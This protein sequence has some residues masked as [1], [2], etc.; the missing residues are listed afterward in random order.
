[1]M[2]YMMSA[3]PLLLPSR[4]WWCVFMFLVSAQPLSTIAIACLR[5]WWQVLNWAAVIGEKDT[6]SGQK[7]GYHHHYMTCCSDLLAHFYWF[8]WPCI[9]TTRVKRFLLSFGYMVRVNL[10]LR[11][12]L[13][14]VRYRY[15]IRYQPLH[16][17]LFYLS[18]LSLRQHPPHDLNNHR[19]YSIFPCR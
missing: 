8:T 13:N 11:T 14:Y 17:M 5:E 4:E 9:T 12:S 15:Y 3:Q 10:P 2:D 6:A 16:Q 1:M 7:S 18:L 19:P